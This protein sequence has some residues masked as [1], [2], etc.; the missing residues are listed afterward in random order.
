[1]SEWIHAPEV[2]AIAET[3]ID[4]VD[5]HADLRQVRIEYVF[6]DKAPKSK[7]MVVWGRARK[8]SGLTAFFALDPKRRPRVFTTPPPF[9]VI[10]ISHDIWQSLDDRQRRALVDHE[11]SHCTVDI[12]E[13]GVV[14]L[15]TIGHGIEEFAGV[16]ERNGLWSPSTERFARAVSSHVAVGIAALEAHANDITPPPAADGD[17]A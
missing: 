15:G 16:V 8:L 13:H 17:G 6:I 10:E 14:V 2:E 12:D 4:V 3:L 11:L 1:M 9:F 5:R 7:G